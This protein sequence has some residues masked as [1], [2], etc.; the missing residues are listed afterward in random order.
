MIDH[1]TFLSVA[2]SAIAVS[3]LTW[4]WLHNPDK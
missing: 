1:Q 2:Y 4:C 3:A